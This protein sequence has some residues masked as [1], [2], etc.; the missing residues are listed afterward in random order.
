MKDTFNH[1]GYPIVLKVI[2]TTE[3]VAADALKQIHLAD[4]MKMSLS[5]LIMSL[6]E[7][8]QCRTDDGW[9]RLAQVFGYADSY[10]LRDDGKTMIYDRMAKEITLRGHEEKPK[11]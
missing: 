2:S 10:A 5:D 3:P 1:H 11:A 7:E 4:Q 8:Q 9:N 6:L